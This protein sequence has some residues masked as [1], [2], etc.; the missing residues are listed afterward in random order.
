MIKQTDK[1]LESNLFNAT[2]SDMSQISSSVRSAISMYNHIG[3][4]LIN[5]S[6]NNNNNNNNNNTYAIMS[7]LKQKREELIVYLID[8]VFVD[9]S[10]YN[11]YNSSN[12]ET[13]KE[14]IQINCEMLSFAVGEAIQTTSTS[15]SKVLSYFGNVVDDLNNLTKN[16]SFDNNRMNDDT[17]NAIV[18]GVVNIAFAFINNYNSNDTTDNEIDNEATVEL[19]QLLLDS[20]LLSKLNGVLPGEQ[21]YY[22]EYYQ[23][24][25][26]DE[27]NGEYS[28]VADARR[29]SST[30]V[31]TTYVSGNNGNGSEEVVCGSNFVAYHNIGAIMKEKGLSTMDCLFS[32]Q[33]WQIWTEIDINS[34]AN[35]HAN[36]N[37]N[38]PISDILS[39]KFTQINGDEIDGSSLNSDVSIAAIVDEILDS[40][41]SINDT[42]QLL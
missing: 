2:T 22:H 25:T 20:I 27:N 1:F 34:N 12:T 32:K 29:Q 3:V 8:T 39:L 30:G 11:N 26:S 35:A 15:G 17:A 23:T 14:F 21:A 24:L 6:N 42:L 28:V 5:N 4:Q 10:N 36:G 37:R 40:N 38:Y 41:I 33:P 16:D 7:D 13:V 31:E 18:S 19:T 9:M